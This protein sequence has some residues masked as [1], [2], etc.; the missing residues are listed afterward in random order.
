[1]RWDGLDGTCKRAWQ[2]RRQITRASNKSI[3][4][5]SVHT[6][7]H[8]AVRY[9]QAQLRRNALTLEVPSSSLEHAP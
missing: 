5:I 4:S 2:K 3:S 7:T 9:K 8:A 1:M 6:K